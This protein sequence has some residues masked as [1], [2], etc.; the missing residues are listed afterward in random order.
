MELVDVKKQIKQG[1]IN[2]FYIFAGEETGIMKIYVNQI[3]KTLGLDVEYM[4]TIQDALSRTS[5]SSLVER[6]KVYVVQD[7]K[8]FMKN[9]KLWKLVN[10]YIKKDTLIAI[11]T[12]I[13]KRSAF[14]KNVD[15][16]AFSTMS[17]EVLSRHIRKELAMSESSSKQLAEICECSYNRCLQEIDK[18]KSYID[19]NK[20]N[21]RIIDGDIAFRE[22][23]NDGQIYKPI[24]D[25][26]FDV[27][28]AIMDRND[29]RKIEKLMIQVKLKSEPKLLLI[30]LLY[31]NFRALLMVQD[32]RGD[33]DN[34]SNSTGLS[35]F[36]I[37]S[38][39]Y[40]I[41]RYS[42][43]EIIRA[44]NILQSLEYGV[45]TGTISEDISMDYF[46]AQVI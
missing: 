13:D 29:I 19:Y 26:T 41:G 11:Y 33:P 12:K 7:D 4:E 8:L 18:M 40:R 36:E 10:K 3:A 14:F 39:K 15:Y 44:M 16:V 28:N 1:N 27:V 21:N 43:P 17:V 6:S 37:R 2:H 25:I 23:L 32:Y 22:L 5:R 35:N 9:E 30:S 24:G 42:T 38:A 46:I 31:N 45:K 20:C 34:L